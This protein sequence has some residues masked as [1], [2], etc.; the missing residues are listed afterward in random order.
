MCFLVQMVCL[1]ENCQKKRTHILE[2]FN[3]IIT[4]HAVL[5]YNVHALNSRRLFVYDVLFH[6][7]KFK[8]ATILCISF[9]KCRPWPYLLLP[10]KQQCPNNMFTLF[11]TIKNNFIEQ[12]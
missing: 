4:V 1:S 11:S 5:L 12:M 2:M 8:F 3:I 7:V 9:R 10:W 6:L